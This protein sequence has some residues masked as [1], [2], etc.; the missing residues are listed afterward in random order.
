MEEVGN[1][2]IPN[3]L[4]RRTY[5]ISTS[6]PFGFGDVPQAYWSAASTI[7]PNPDIRWETTITRN[8]GLDFGFLKNKITGTLEYY[9]NTTKDLLV[10]KVIPTN[11][12]YTSQIITLGKLRT[13]EWN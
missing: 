10:T 2:R 12:G 4:W 5:G 11:T 1:N 7:M 3:D 8:I 6:R 9:R 13:V